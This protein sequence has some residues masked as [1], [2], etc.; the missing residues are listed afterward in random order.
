MADRYWVSGTG[1]WDQAT[2]THWSATSGGAGGASVP[3]A[4]DDVY[5]DGNSGTGNVT[6]TANAPCRSLDCTGYA[7][8]LTHNTG[9]TVSIGDGTAGQGSIALKLVAGMT[10]TRAGSSSSVFSFISTSGTQQTVDHAGKTVGAQTF[11]GAGGSWKLMGGFT[12]GGAFT[13]TQGSL[14]VNGQTLTTTQLVST[15]SSTRSITL[16]AA[17]ITLTGTSNGTLDM[18]TTGLTFSAGT[19]LITLSGTAGGT[20]FFRG[21]GNTFYDVAFTGLDGAFPPQIAGANGWHNISRSNGNAIIFTAGV[22][23]TI[24]G[25]FISGSATNHILVRSS[26]AGSAWTLSKA[27]G[28]VS[29][30]FVSLKDTTATGGATFSAGSNSVSISGNSGWTFVASRLFVLDSF[31][32]AS[33]TVLSSHTGELGATWAQ[34]GSY[35]TATLNVSNANRVRHDSTNAVKAAYYA[36]ATPASADYDVEGVLQIVSTLN[37]NLAL[38]G[39]VDTAADT[40]YA[41]GLNPSTGGWFLAKFVAGAQTNLKTGTVTVNA[42]E[43]HTLRLRMQGSRISIAWDGT[44]LDSATDSA[45]TAAGKV[46]IR[47][48][49]V[50]TSDSTGIHVDA[51]AAYN[52]V[53]LAAQS[54]GT[55]SQTSGLTVARPLA[56]QSDGVGSVQANATVSRPLVG[57][58]DGAGATQGDVTV[59]RPLE[60]LSAGQATAQGDVTVSRSL[61]GQGDGTSA[62]AGELGVAVALAGDSTGQGTTS[63]DLLVARL[64]AGS[65]TG[66]SSATAALSHTY[67]LAGQSMGSS[68]VTGTMSSGV[69]LEG[70]AKGTS[71]ATGTLHFRPRLP[72]F[73]ANPDTSPAVGRLETLRTGR[74][75]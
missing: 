75:G 51:I 67:A 38:V 40:M 30:D 2:T 20:G 58:S 34:H 45:I 27:S 9:V 17:Q 39:R 21:G 71:T 36:S 10:Y 22:T 65:S 69:A 18:T 1:N 63:A 55:S 35:P 32:D 46:G 25:S 59:S 64:L 62:A 3:V 15:G 14:D 13:I 24:T 53:V 8:T 70:S 16:G 44:E 29:V 48:N 28:T 4:G 50:A 42:G 47:T 6:I 41:A 7:G 68:T 19:S 61:E 37:H 49:A 26:S 57:Q 33:N 74:Y 11:N 54:D 73:S 5:L 66:A 31:V 23:Q 43:T 72:A 12:S 52:A 56:G 60:G